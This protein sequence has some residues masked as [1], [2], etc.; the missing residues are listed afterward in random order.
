MYILRMHINLKN[1]QISFLRHILYGKLSSHAMV[2]GLIQRQFGR[3]QLKRSMVFTSSR[4]YDA[5]FIIKFTKTNWILN[6]LK[7]CFVCLDVK[8][9]FICSFRKKMASDC[10]IGG[11]KLLTTFAVIEREPKEHTDSALL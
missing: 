4:K 9:I 7:E 3:L 11:G 8:S 6:R 5:I 2:I 10:N 1:F